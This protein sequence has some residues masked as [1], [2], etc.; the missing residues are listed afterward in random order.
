MASVLVAATWAEG[1]KKILHS[2]KGGHD[3]KYP[4]YP[5][6]IF[7]KAG[8]LYGTTFDGGKY[9]LGTVFELT[10]GPDG[11]WSETVLHAFAG[12]RD[13]AFPFSGLVFDRAGNL[14]GT[15]G[16]GGGLGSCP[17]E[18]VNY[19]CG[20]VF[21][22]KPKANGR[23]TETVL[24][25][26]DEGTYGGYLKN[27]LIVDEAGNLYGT[28]EGGDGCQ[29]HNCGLVFEL[30][31][32]KKGPWKE[33]ILHSFHGPDGG[34]PQSP[35]IF[36]AEGDLYGTTIGGGAAYAG[37]VFELVPTKRG[38][39]KETVL[40]SFDPQKYDGSRPCGFLAL[41]AE[42]NLYGATQNGGRFPCGGSGCG[43]VYRLTNHTWKETILF[44]L[45]GIANDVAG[46]AFDSLGNLYGAASGTELHRGGIFELIPQQGG[47]WQEQ[48][49][50]GFAPHTTPGRFIYG[51]DGNLYGMTYFGGAYDLGAVFRITP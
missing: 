7:D 41:D 17:I 32:T 29:Q 24:R 15:T 14:Y 48:L 44:Y 4:T 46:I 11:S 37:V 2:F 38:P 19:F 26:F 42:G 50:Y 47:E 45:K 25:R 51:A 9:G 20:T 28:A 12:D 40:H 22:L 3:G 23:W 39:W 34:D 1:T 16:W 35:L 27:N 49:I 8:N 36:D 5:G 31:P 6:L 10:P 18:S 33:K 13:G 30:I 21:E 43:V